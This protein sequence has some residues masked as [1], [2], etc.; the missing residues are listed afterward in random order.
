MDG[1]YQAPVAALQERFGVQ[2]SE[3]RAE[4]TGVV[5]AEQLVEAVLAL[6]DEFGFDQ[7]VD[8]TAVDYWPQ[9]T[10]RFHVVYHI[11]NLADTLILCLRVPLD[12]NSPSAPTLEGVHPGANWY[13]REVY[14]MF[15]VTFTGHS[16][17]RRILMPADWQG[18]PLRK[19][20]PLGYEEVAFSFNV[21]E[22]MKRKP[23]PK[24]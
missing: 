17:M 20:Y 5:T 15:G 11:R 24:E 7:L 14:D 22:I 8:L 4:V 16:D 3:S 10:P 21:D 13:E 6:R 18:H 2:I 1:K 9:E 19:D 23:H 12:G